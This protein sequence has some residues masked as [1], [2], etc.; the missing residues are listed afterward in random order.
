MTDDTRDSSPAITTVAIEP[1]ALQP[2]DASH[3]DVVV[4][5][6]TS[7]LSDR[8]LKREG[9]EDHFLIAQIDRTWRTVQTNMPADALPQYATESVTSQ[10]VADGMGGAAAGEVASRTAIGTFVD[11]VL[12]T[13]YLILRLDKQSTRDVMTRM[14]ARF[15]QITQALEAAVRRDPTL[16]GMGTTMTLVA[17]FRADLLV[18]HVGD[19]RAYLYRQGR[20]ERLTRDQTM[21]QSLLEKGAISP[22]EIAT[23]PLRHLL[24]GVLGTKGKPIDV[25]LH[26]V[27]LEDRDQVLLC[28]DGLTEMVPEPMIADVLEH[29]LTAE[30]AC[31]QLIDLANSRGGK[32]NVTA[33]VSRYQV[34]PAS[35]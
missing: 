21:V 19:S 14:A 27:G 35:A 4:T 29:A 33:V 30:A 12:R 7:G 15:A 24:S 17:N 1:A 9:N 6:E 5:V 23:H 16:A 13:P 20:L 26:F 32:D 10:I 25:E 31:K 28:T 3:Q 8:G 11:I 34:T 18:A 22:D 2:A